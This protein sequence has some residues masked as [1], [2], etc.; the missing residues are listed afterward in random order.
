[1]VVALVFYAASTFEGSMLAIKSANALSHYT[2]WT[3]AH[4]HSGA[5]GWV[6]M[7]TIG[8]VYAMAPRALGRPMHSVAAMNLHFWMH[9]IGLLMYVVAMWI[10]G[11]TAGKMWFA[12]DTNGQL[13]YSFMESLRAMHPYYVIR[14]L[15]G[16]LVMGGMMVMAWNLWH[17]AA[18][19]R[20]NLITPIPIPVPVPEPDQV[21]PP[22]TVGGL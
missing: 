17:T 18:Q 13:V 7:I 1:M 8:S 9:I 19:A 4:V 21:P 14:F 2:D 11:I 22:L 20:A 3:V 16:T 12:T 6:A 10:S 5:I 15:G